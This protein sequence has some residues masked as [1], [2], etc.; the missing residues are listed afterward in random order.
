M[1]KWCKFSGSFEWYLDVPD[2]AGAVKI[3]QVSFCMHAFRTVLMADLPCAT[4]WTWTSSRSLIRALE[5]I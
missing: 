2:F 5:R 4:W 3:G 1:A